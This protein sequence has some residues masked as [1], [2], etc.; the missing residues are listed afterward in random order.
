M[1]YLKEH[2]DVLRR[3]RQ[4]RPATRNDCTFS[5]SSALVRTW[6]VVGLPAR[7]EAVAAVDGPIAGSRGLAAA[8]AGTGPARSRPPRVASKGSARRPFGRSP[9]PTDPDHAASR[10]RLLRACG[11]PAGH[12][13]SFARWPIVAWPVARWSRPERAGTRWIVG[14]RRRPDP[15]RIG[16]ARPAPRSLHP[17]SGRD[18]ALA[19][20]GALER[21]GAAHGLSLL[22]VSRRMEARCRGLFGGISMGARPRRRATDSSTSSPARSVRSRIAGRSRRAPGPPWSSSS[23]ASIRLV[24]LDMLMTPPALR[25]RRRSRATQDQGP[26]SLSRTRLEEGTVP[27]L[28]QLQPSGRP[29]LPR[30]ETCVVGPSV[31]QAGGGSG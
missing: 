12:R 21:V 8:V 2:D 20:V 28:R 7:L 30:R 19:L 15:G 6:P 24:A 23:S 16:R 13:A 10:C 26:R 1:S 22:R 11:D 31:R 25:R 5:T 27:T 14:G 18:A 17:H 4:R 3:N 29:V 9:T